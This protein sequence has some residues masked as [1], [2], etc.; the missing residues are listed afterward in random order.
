VNASQ[1]ESV[2]FKKVADGYLYR[3]PGLWLFGAGRHYLVNEAQKADIARILKLK[4]ANRPILTGV[5]LGVFLVIVV[6]AWA[7]FGY[8]DREPGF[9]D[10][11]LLFVMLAGSILALLQVF[12]WVQLYRLQPL[13]AHLPRSNERISFS[14]L[15]EAAR[16]SQPV[17]DLISVG[18]TLAFLCSVSMFNVG[19]GLGLAI[20]K[21]H[22]SFNLYAFAFLAILLGWAAFTRFRL[23]MRKAETLENPG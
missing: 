19:L 17:K 7:Y 5:I 8:H 18:A 21:G 4:Q 3:A 22:G 6:M 14:E 9:A 13:L 23:A 20:A 15:R 2:V 16:K 12:S 11:F 10:Y 1:I